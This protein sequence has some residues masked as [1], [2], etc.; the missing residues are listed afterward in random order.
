MLEEPTLSAPINFI[1]EV[2]DPSLQS[3]LGGIVA[4]LSLTFTNL[5][6]EN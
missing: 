5:T 3:F 2:K 6:Q 1:S 4:N